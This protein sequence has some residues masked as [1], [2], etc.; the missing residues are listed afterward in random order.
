[1]TRKYI[2]WSLALWRRRLASRRVKLARAQ[3]ALT[4]ALGAAQPQFKVPAARR[5]VARYERLKDE[6]LV[7]VARRKKQLAAL[8]PTTMSE[9]G[10]DFIKEFEG[11]YSHP[12]DDGVGVK[13]IGWGFVAHD[14]PNGEVPASMTRS[15]GDELLTK[16]LSERYVPPVVACARHYGIT[17]SQNELDALASFSFNLGS[18]AFDWRHTSGF[19]SLHR[20]FR[21]KSKRQIADTL[22]LYSNPGDANVHAG[23]LRRRKA[24]RKLFL[25]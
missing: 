5:R 22:Q 24:E 23:L 13:T 12:Y 15:A 8:A 16:I 20:A 1:M 19:E 11:W 10:V 18:G 6:A 14:F 2:E 17:L 4:A 21:S 7:N 9:R 3:T 25:G